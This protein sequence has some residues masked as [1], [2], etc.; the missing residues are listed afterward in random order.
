MFNDS[1]KMNNWIPELKSISEKET[2]P[3]KVGSTY[4]M[5]VTNPNGEEITLEEKILAFV[6]DEKVTIFFRADNMLKTDDYT[7]DFENGVTTVVNNSVCRS[8]SYILS[9]VFPYFKSKFQQQDQGY[10]DNFKAF[11][12]KQ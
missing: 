4:H 12:E 7:F 5:V 9:C 11:A 10:L 1:S 2:K 3:G 6:P 8:D